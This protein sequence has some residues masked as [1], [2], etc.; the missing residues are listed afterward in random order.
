MHRVSLVMQL[1]L[2]YQILHDIH[3]RIGHLK[4]YHKMK[5]GPALLQ[6]KLLLTSQIVMMK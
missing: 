5:N 3:V 6:Y 1:E 4:V 2:L